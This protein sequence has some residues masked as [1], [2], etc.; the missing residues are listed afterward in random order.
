MNY[1]LN[2][3]CDVTQQLVLL[4]TST[5]G[6]T[7]F[8]FSHFFARFS[9]ILWS[10]FFGCNYFCHNGPSQAYVFSCSTTTHLPSFGKDIKYAVYCNGILPDRPF[11]SNSATISILG[12]VHSIHKIA[13]RQNQLHDGLMCSNRAPSFWTFYA[14]SDHV[15]DRVGLA[16]R[17][18]NV[19]FTS[20]KI[21]ANRPFELLLNP[22]LAF[23][24]ALASLDATT[25]VSPRSYSS[26]GCDV[27]T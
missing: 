14:A 17:T 6:K 7:S 25:L 24:I 19:S 16:R 11:S 3:Q 10:Y 27:G 9:P 5:F 18:P 2:F 22:A 15:L 21:G 12:D 26:V 13:G 20:G 23:C 4:T 8:H 1:F